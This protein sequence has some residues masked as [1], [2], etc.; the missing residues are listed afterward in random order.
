MIVVSY[1]VYR[2]RHAGRHAD[3][4]Y[5]MPGGV[6]MCWAILVFFLFV[7]W[8]LS[9]QAETAVALAWFPAWFVLLAAGWLVARRRPGRAD[10]YRMFHAEMNN[11]T[12]T[13]VSEHG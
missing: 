10:R 13:G 3:S 5:K 4:I 1:L 6:A 2:R 11:A 8:T 9:T 12:Q 7:I